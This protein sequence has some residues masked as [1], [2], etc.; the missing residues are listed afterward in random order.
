MGLG[1]VTDQLFTTW[2]FASTSGSATRTTPARL[3]D[4]FNVKDFGALGNSTD[5]TDGADDTTAIENAIAASGASGR[6]EIFFPRGNYRVTRPILLEG[7]LDS[8]VIRGVGATYHSTKSGS[9]VGGT[10][11]GF[12]FQRVH[13][14]PSSQ[15]YTRAIR[16]IGV[17]NL[18]ETWGSDLGL[19]AATS[20]GAYLY[21]TTTTPHGITVG[22]TM[23]IQVAGVTGVTA[24]NG[25][26]GVIATS[27]TGIKVHNTVATYGAGTVGSATCKIT[28]GGAIALNGSLHGIVAGCLIKGY[29]G[30]W[31]HQDSTISVEDCLLVCSGSNTVGSVAFMTGGQARMT[32]CDVCF[33]ET[34]IA[35]A[36]IGC[37]G[38][39]VGGGSRFEHNTVG[40]NLSGVTGVRIGGMSFEANDVYGIY[41]HGGGAIDIG[42]INMFGL[43]SAAAIY[44]DGAAGFIHDVTIGGSF[45][46]AGAAQIVVAAGS[47]SSGLRFDRVIAGGSSSGGAVQT[48]IAK[49]GAQISGCNFNGPTYTIAELPVSSSVFPPRF[50]DQ[51][52]C[53]DVHNTDAVFGG[54]AG[55]T[56]TGANKR[57]VE[58]D[59]TANAWYVIGVWT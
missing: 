3:D 19:S 11:P 31:G 50:R 25:F 55:L 58:Y 43:N 21:F 33:W 15:A 14:D 10:F 7:G 22:R 20:D 6:G 59:L 49:V 34:G 1:R 32:H 23:L 16:D 51:L 52:R 13:E 2:P 46:G 38:L 8:F 5:F 56:G 36:A 4:V 9:V 27:S 26:W 30:V 57:W 35:C 17:V 29:Y 54:K 45:T 12:V 24:Y 37:T 40:M 28:P 18:N 48:D 44:I 41:I 47:N 53:S 42:S 39:D